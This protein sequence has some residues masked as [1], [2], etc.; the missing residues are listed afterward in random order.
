MNYKALKAVAL[1]V[2]LIGSLLYAGQAVY[3]QTSTCSDVGLSTFFEPEGG[4]GS[5]ST[6]CKGA[7]K[8]CSNGY[9]CVSQSGEEVYDSSGNYCGRQ[10]TCVPPPVNGVCAATQNNCSQGTSVDTADT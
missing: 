9:Q 1:F 4:S 2:L 6:Q 8:T 5:Q 3:A 10:A 7:T